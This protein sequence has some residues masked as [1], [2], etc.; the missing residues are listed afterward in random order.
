MPVDFLRSNSK[1]MNLRTN[2]I[3]WGQSAF[4]FIPGNKIRPKWTDLELDFT[5]L[6]YKQ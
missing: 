6:Q 4:V 2:Q 5:N 1:Q 3:W